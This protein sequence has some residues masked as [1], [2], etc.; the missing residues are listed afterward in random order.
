MILFQGLS[1]KLII[2]LCSDRFVSTYK[3]VPI[4]NEKNR[5]QMLQNIKIVDDSNETYNNEFYTKSKENN[6]IDSTGF[7]NITSTNNIN[8]TSHDFESGDKIYY[9]SSSPSEG[10]ADKNSYFIFKVECSWIIGVFL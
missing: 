8:I 10:L 2:L 5:L 9:S 4:I 1:I 7:Y 3:R 6:R